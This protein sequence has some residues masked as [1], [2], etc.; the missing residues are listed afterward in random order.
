MTGQ[1]GNR[2]KTKIHFHVKS[3]NVLV[4]ASPGLSQQHIFKMGETVGDF[5]TEEKQ[6]TEKQ[7]GKTFQE[8][9]WKLQQNELEFN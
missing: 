3:K 2:F 8:S 9:T 5:Q 6:T 7:H 1:D 4:D